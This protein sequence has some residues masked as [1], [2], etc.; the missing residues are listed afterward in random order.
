M[1]LISQISLEKKEFTTKAR[2]TRSREEEVLAERLKKHMANFE[3]NFLAD[4]SD[5]S[6]AEELKRIA[7]FLGKNFVSKKD[8]ETHG[9]LSY[10]VINKHFGSLRK[11]LEYAGLKPQRYMNASDTELLKI[12][13]ELWETTLEKEGRPPQRKDLKAFDFPVSG[14]TYTRHFGSWK[15][16]LI[17]AF[18][19]VNSEGLDEGQILIKIHAEKK[20]KTSRSLSLRKRFFVMKRDGFTCCMCGANG[21]GVKLEID[22]VVPVAKGGSDALGNLQTLCFECNRGKR[23]SL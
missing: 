19:T 16:A 8:I 18:E 17:K 5:E 20:V 12:L 3:I 7:K 13:V 4:Y 9:K 10:S 14:D 11:A 21:R 2:R 15:K 23:D 22:H 1:T 6:I